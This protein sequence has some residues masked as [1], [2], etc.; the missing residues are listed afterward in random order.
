[1]NLTRKS[2][3]FV[4]ACVRAVW[5]RGGIPIQ[6]SLPPL[7]LSPSW[8]AELSLDLLGATSFH[9]SLPPTPPN[10]LFIF[11]WIYRCIYI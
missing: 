8:G 5:L 3:G 9:F 6:K 10:L 4:R 2:F 7:S 1:M 11:S